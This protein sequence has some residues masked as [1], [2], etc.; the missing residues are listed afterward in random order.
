MGP[1][2][3]LYL[4]VLVGV[5]GSGCIWSE[6][7]WQTRTPVDLLAQYLFLNVLWKQNQTKH[8]S[9]RGNNCESVSVIG[10]S[11]CCWGMVMVWSISEHLFIYFLNHTLVYQGVNIH[12]LSSAWWIYSSTWSP[13]CVLPPAGDLKAIQAQQFLLGSCL[14]NNQVCFIICLYDWLST[15]W[16]WC[17]CHK[18]NCIKATKTI[19]LNYFYLIN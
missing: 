12:R 17:T 14:D 19:L 8:K 16:W 3:K 6:S 7:L 1:G 11:K 15:K 2:A 4:Q 13:D 5:G 10:K 18:S 9:C